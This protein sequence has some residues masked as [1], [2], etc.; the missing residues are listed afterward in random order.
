MSYCNKRWWCI[1]RRLKMMQMLMVIVCTSVMRRSC[2]CT[3]YYYA[4]MVLINGTPSFLFQCNGVEREGNQFPGSDFQVSIVGGG[5]GG[6]CSLV[7]ARRLQYPWESQPSPRH[8]HRLPIRSFY[9]NKSPI[10]NAQFD[11]F[12]RSTHY[13]PRLT[14]NFLRH[15]RN[16]AVPSGYAN[17]PV[18]WVDVL[19]AQTYCQ[20][21][22]GRLPNEVCAIVLVVVVVVIVIVI[23][24]SDNNQQPPRSGVAVRGAT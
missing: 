2:T 22:G 3:Q 19:D 16:G 1:R 21:R 14:A 9:I 7:S 23:V 5:G 8:S 17:K 15:W 4:D 10:T 11:S 6:V 12:V 18:V 13:S 24:T 20:S